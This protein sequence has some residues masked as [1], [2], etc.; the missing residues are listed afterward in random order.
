MPSQP[1]R[2]SLSTVHKKAELNEEDQDAA[3]QV[4]SAAEADHEVITEVSEEGAANL[5]VRDIETLQET[6]NPYDVE[7]GRGRPR[8]L[9]KRI[10]RAIHNLFYRPPTPEEMAKKSEKQKRQA[11]DKMLHREADRLEEIFWEEF[12]NFGLNTEKKGLFKKR[13]K[14]KHRRSNLQAHYFK[15]DMLH[16]P[17]KVNVSHVIHD[18]LLKNLEIACGLPV[19]IRANMKDGSVFRVD[20]AGNSSGVP[21]HVAIQE[22]W[23]RFPG[24]ADGLSIGFGMANNTRPIFYS[25]ADMHHLLIAGTT[26]GGKSNQIKAILCTYVRR[27]A[28]N[29]LKILLIDLKRMDFRPFAGIPHLVTLKL[30]REIVEEADEEGH[31]EKWW[32]VKWITD[33]DYK[34]EPEEDQDLIDV[35]DPKDVGIIKDKNRVLQGLDWAKHEMERR[36]RLFDEDEGKPANI[37]EYNQ[38]HRDHPLYRLVIVFDEYGAMS[39]HADG[40]KTM[41]RI[42]SIAE[43]GRAAGIHLII[44]TQTPTSAVINGRIK[45]NIPAKLAFNCSN[46]QG[47]MAILGNAAAHDLNWEGRAI[48]DFKKTVEMQTPLINKE[49]IESTVNGARGGSFITIQAKHDVT[50]EE[51]MQFALT[52]KKGYLTLRREFS[53]YEHFKDRG[54]S[55]E[56]LEGWLKDWEGKEFIVNDV[57]YEVKPQAARYPRRMVPVE[58]EEKPEEKKD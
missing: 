49:V 31:K 19:S 53:L 17:K 44:S 7:I 36:F 54:I 43:L 23:D 46:M 22:M 55:R 25:L 58:R 45:N 24:H 15:V 27:N 50:P 12:D 57:L 28:P 9:F 20:R 41:D 26:G 3:L 56:E 1:Q 30:L 35:T 39:D 10:G 52:E 4:E 40:A 51:V 48:L 18:D 13:L 6:N 21:A 8:K 38:H 34:T 14:F 32:T 33:P 47:S 29:R 11:E 2:E 5:D 37:A 42:V 16:R